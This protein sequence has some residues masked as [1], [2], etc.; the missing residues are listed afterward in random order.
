MWIPTWGRHERGS[1]DVAKTRHRYPEVG[2]LYGLLICAFAAVLV[3]AN[4]IPNQRIRDNVTAS[5]SHDNYRRSPTGTRIDHS[6]ECIVLN[7]GLGKSA[8]QMG[9]L[10]RSLSSPTLGDCVATGKALLESEDLGF[11]YWR[12]WHGY[13]VISRPILFF[14]DA[15]GLRLISFVV[16]GL[17]YLILF[18]S[19]STHAGREYAVIGNR[20]SRGTVAFP[21]LSDP[22]QRRVGNRILAGSIA[23]AAG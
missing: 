10:A 4:S 16:F 9:P 7:M 13:Q 17:S 5:F 23:L 18:Q 19:I 8:T 21:A 6:T 1:S 22:L 12:Y 3:A 11:N 14:T 2:C 15:Y 20:T